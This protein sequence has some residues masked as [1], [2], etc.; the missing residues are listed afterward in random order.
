MSTSP[1]LE[2]LAASPR[3]VL[4]R[5]RAAD[6][7]QHRRERR[8]D[9]AGTDPAQRR[10]AAA[11]TAAA[12]ARN[13][14]PKTPSAALIYSKTVACC[15]TAPAGLRARPSPSAARVA[16]AGIRAEIHHRDIDPHTET[17]HSTRGRLVQAHPSRE[18]D[19]ARHPV[20]GLRTVLRRERAANE[21]QHRR[22]RRLD[23]AGADP[24]RRRQTWSAWLRHRLIE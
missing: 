23:S 4:R 5:E 24:A 7:A 3:A 10:R 14:N 17:L 2:S 13:P 16:A 21:A 1:C 9:D 15:N 22:E 12:E 8:L 18:A 11:V 19:V 6:E 20:A